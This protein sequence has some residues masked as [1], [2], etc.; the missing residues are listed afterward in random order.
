MAGRGVSFGENMPNV[1]TLK[2]QAEGLLW[3]GPQ[4]MGML[5]ESSGPVAPHE[6]QLGQTSYAGS[7]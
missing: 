2:R 3:P 7:G 6:I 4:A 1:V 5:T